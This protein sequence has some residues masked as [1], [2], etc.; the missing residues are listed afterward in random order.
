MALGQLFRCLHPSA[1]AVE[2]LGV[3]S[4]ANLDFV[5]SHVLLGSLII[6]S[7]ELFLIASFTKKQFIQFIG[8]KYP[9]QII[10]IFRQDLGILLI[11]YCCIS[12]NM[13]R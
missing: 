4:W 6:V 2:L 8:F 10:N 7:W 13:T 12:V 1:G 3:I 9:V 11:Q 5:L